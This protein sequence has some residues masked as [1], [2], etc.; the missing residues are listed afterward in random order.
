MGAERRFVVRA[1]VVLVAIAAGISSAA[2]QSAPNVEDVAL[3]LRS[4][5]AAKKPLL[6]G[7]TGLGGA[8]LLVALVAGRTKPAPVAPSAPRRWAAGPPPGPAPRPQRRLV[9]DPTFGDEK[10]RAL[11]ASLAAGQW[12]VVAEHLRAE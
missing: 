9:D 4:A 12:P 2:A 3:A 10:A 11:K 5:R 1:A 8:I 7:L 6:F